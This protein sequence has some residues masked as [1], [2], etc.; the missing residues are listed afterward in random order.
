MTA[1]ISVK[2]ITALDGC[3]QFSLYKKLYSSLEGVEDIVKW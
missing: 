1:C 2:L 3:M